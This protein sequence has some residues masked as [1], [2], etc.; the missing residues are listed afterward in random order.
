VRSCEKLS[1]CLIKPVPATSKMDPPLAKAKPVSDSDS[2]SVITYLRREKKHCSK[3]AVRREESSYVRE[4]TLQTPRSVKKEGKEVL[5][6][7]EQKV[8]PCSS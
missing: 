6:M 3:L 4:T 1:P 5:E 8:F 2:T 7:P